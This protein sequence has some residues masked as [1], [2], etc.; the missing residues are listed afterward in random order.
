MGARSVAFWR[1][2]HAYAERRL[3]ETYMRTYLHDR[4]CPNCKRWGAVGGFDWGHLREVTP[5]HDALR[6][7][8]CDHES[9]WFMGSML[10]ILTVPGDAYYPT[11]TPPQRAAAPEDQERGT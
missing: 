7:T 6:C 8:V 5:W 10:P 9:L 2:V 4:C 3:R 1:K 11:T